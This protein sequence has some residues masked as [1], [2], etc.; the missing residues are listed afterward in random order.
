MNK[1]RMHSFFVGTIILAIMLSLTT[2]TVFAQEQ[3]QNATGTIFVKD[4]VTGAP[5]KGVTVIIESATST[6]E[7][8]NTVPSS[9]IQ[10][11]LPQATYIVLVKIDIFGIPITLAHTTLDLPRM[12]TLQITV[13]A[14]IV[15]IQYLPLLIYA[16]VA[17][18]IVLIAVSIVYRVRKGSKKGKS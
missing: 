13:S 14:Q 17:I 18:I 16:V 2:S 4:G 10:V 9:G 1:S 3:Q 8:F 5:A 6:I 12:T 11:T 7:T 15:P